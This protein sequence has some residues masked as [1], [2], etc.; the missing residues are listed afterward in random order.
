[1]IRAQI[2]SLPERVRSLEKTIGSL[3]P[4]V[5][6]IQVALNNYKELPALGHPKIK[7]I[8]LDNSLGDGA[9]FYGVE[10]FEGYFFSCDDDLI[11]PPDYVQKMIAAINQ[12]HCIVTLHGKIFGSRPIRS[13]HHGATEKLR[14]LGVVEN[15]TFVD[16]CGSGVS[17][18]H[19]DDFKLKLS[20]FEKPNMADIWMSK[21]AHEQGVKMLCL[22]HP[23]GYLGY[24]HFEDNI[25]G[26]NNRNESFQTELV[27]FFLK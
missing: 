5:N 16:V 4:Q 20:D 26:N 8:H 18:F 7:Y 11:Y 2:A 17:A 24:N 15:D 27:N 21:K 14:C 3:F 6:C 10:E 19:T 22:A 13:Y 23:I 9:K 12:Y 1:M 25:Y